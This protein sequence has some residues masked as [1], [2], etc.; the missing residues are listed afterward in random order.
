MVRPR[1]REL[2][3]AA[4][5]RQDAE[6]RNLAPATYL[7]HLEMRMIRYLDFAEFGAEGSELGEVVAGDGAA[8]GVHERQPDHR[9]RQHLVAAGDL[10]KRDLE[11]FKV[12]F[13][14]YPL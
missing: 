10:K 14:S 3:S 9:V 4:G 6:S 11:V 1:L 2:A 7:L 13:Q 12:W 5:G 8:L